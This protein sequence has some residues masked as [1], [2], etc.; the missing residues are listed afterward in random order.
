MIGPARID[1]RSWGETMTDHEIEL[2]L[3]TDAN[4]AERLG[5]FPALRSAAADIKDQ[6]STYYDTN[7]RTLQKA[8]ISLRVRRTG[9]QTIQTEKLSADS[10]GLFSR[11]EWEWPIAGDTPDRTVLVGTPAAALLG[12]AALVPVVRTLVTRTIWRV[13]RKLG[14]IEVSLDKGSVW[15]ENRQVAINE[16][17]LELKAGDQR[18]LFDFADELA[19]QAQVR[20]AVL[21]KVERGFALAIGKLGKM[22]KASPVWVTSEMNVRDGFTTIVRS[23]V[24]HFRLNEEPLTRDRDAATLHQARVAMRRLRSAFSLF[25]PALKDDVFGD[26]RAELRWFTGELGSARNLD[27]LIERVRARN[28]DVPAEMLAMREE[29]YDAAIAA[30][31]SSRFQRLM[32]DLV[33]WIEIGEWRESKKARRPLPPFAEKRLNRLWERVTAAASNLDDL[34]EQQ[35]HR[36]RIGIKKLRYASEFLSGLYSGRAAEMERLGK[37]LQALQESLGHLNDLVTERTILKFLP[38]GAAAVTPD[39]CK[40]DIEKQHLT[41]ARKQVRQLLKAGPVW[42]TGTES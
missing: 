17:E 19:R 16:I 11:S 1:Y 13:E 21:S 4:G 2:K 31:S 20:L 42:R 33:R 14:T 38:A 27:V 8:G 7:S 37:V 15:A 41:A 18:I 35:R 22:T 36:L 28:V 30:V 24:K 26:L 29:A 5:S 12:V 34:D 3:E 32:L 39:G 25:W 6:D 10:A 40:V 9:S 23:C